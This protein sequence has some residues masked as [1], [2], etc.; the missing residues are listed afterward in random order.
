MIAD[1]FYAKLDDVCG[2]CPAHDAKIILRDFNTQVRLERFFDPSVRLFSL[3]ANSNSNGMRLI[4]LSAASN[5]VV[6]GT[7]FQHLNIHKITFMSHDRSTFN[8]IDHIVTHISMVDAYT[9][10]DPNIDTD[11]F[12]VATKFRLRIS[13]LRSA[14]SNAL[15]K[16]D[17]KKLRSQRTAETLSTQLPDRLQRFPCNLS[18]IGGL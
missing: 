6:C 12:L 5:M 18:Y 14:R 13:A 17:V 15:R 2:R 3:H 16:L 10:W 1:A 11:H 7:K 8:Q 9:F 4:D